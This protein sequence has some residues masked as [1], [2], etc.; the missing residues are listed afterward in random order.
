M[1]EDVLGTA[2]EAGELGI[3]VCELCGRPIPEDALEHEAVDQ[4]GGA[5]PVEVINVCPRCKRA[6]GSDESPFDLSGAVG[7]IDIEE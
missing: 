2:R 6:L 3:Q 5:E 4:G 1:D 7:P